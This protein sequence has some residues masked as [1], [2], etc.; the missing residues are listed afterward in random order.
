MIHLPVQE[1]IE[2]NLIPWLEMVP[3]NIACIK[4]GAQDVLYTGRHFINAF[5]G[6]GGI[7]GFY[8]SDVLVGLV[9]SFINI[10]DKLIGLEGGGID[11][12]LVPVPY[13]I[14]F[15]VEAIGLSI[16][17]YMVDIFSVHVFERIGKNSF[18]RSYVYVGKFIEY[19][20]GDG[21]AGLKGSI[22]DP[23]KFIARL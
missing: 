17:Y 4:N 16:P 18:S 14:E 13:P 19:F 8:E 5:R 12:T 9:P 2:G 23:A 15:I 21:L 1:H 11:I 3:L 6:D 20:I 10:P 22:M 7:S